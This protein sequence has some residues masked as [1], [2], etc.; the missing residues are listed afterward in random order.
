M[1]YSNTNARTVERRE[2][3][4]ISHRT[5]REFVR[6][7]QQA[8]QGGTLCGAGAVAVTPEADQSA[9]GAVRL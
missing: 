1:P 8:D 6:I 7:S 4:T 9:Q 5:K 3:C 2:W